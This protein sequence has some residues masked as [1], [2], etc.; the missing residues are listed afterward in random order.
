MINVL[1]EQQKK[2][3]KR[4]YIFRLIATYFFLFGILSVLATLLLLPTY[5]LS[6]SKESFLNN[7]LVRLDEENP[8]LSLDEL[9]NIISDINTKLVLLDSEE[10]KIITQDVLSKFL[11]ISR[12]NIEIHK[13]FYSRPEGKTQ[14]LEVSG[15]AKDRSSLSQYKSALEESNLYTKVDLPISNFVEKVDINFNIKL[16][17]KSDE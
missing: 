12:K 3:L 1:P 4:E 13:I 16:E 17:L 11:L 6:K 14:V 2:E 5:I 15:L 10:N 7:E 9:K 8:D